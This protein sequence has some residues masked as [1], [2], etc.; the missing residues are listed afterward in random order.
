[1]KEENVTGVDEKG[2]SE[3]TGMREYVVD[4][5]KITVMSIHFVEETGGNPLFSTSPYSFEVNKKASNSLT[6]FLVFVSHA[7]KIKIKKND[8]Q[9]LK[10]RSHYVVRK[11]KQIAQK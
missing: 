10:K 6:Y 2:Q 1:M 7:R 5:L 11:L 9:G 8:Q 3:V 4:S